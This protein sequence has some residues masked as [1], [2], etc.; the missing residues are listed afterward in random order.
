MSE[1]VF[2]FGVT[3]LAISA[4]TAAATMFAPIAGTSPPASRVCAG[5]LDSG[6]FRPAWCAK[7]PP[8]KS[9][10]R[11]RKALAAYQVNATWLAEAIATAIGNYQPISA[12]CKDNP[13]VDS[14]FVDTIIIGGMRLNGGEA[15][16]QAE[17]A[18]TDMT[19]VVDAVFTDSPTV[20]AEVKATL[21][22]LR[23]NLDGFGRIMDDLELAGD[24]YKMSA[25]NA[26]DDAMES[27]A[28][29]LV[30]T[31]QFSN[32]TMVSL[33]TMLGGTQERCKTTK[34][35]DPFT[36]K[37]MR[38]TAGATKTK[39][40]SAGDISMQYPTSLDVGGKAVWLPINLDSEAPS[41]Y[42]QVELTQDSK[43][44]A[45]VGGG[46]PADES[47][48]RI[49]VLGKPKRGKAMLRLTFQAAGGVEAI[50]TVTLRLR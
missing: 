22:G 3:T 9:H 18:V 7:K 37:A 6:E 20:P 25:C 8:P 43:R 27:A 28:E 15:K 4:V 46:T 44:L 12:Q 38:K 14:T 49:K 36:N 2:M 32:R 30:T 17:K 40:T 29:D 33:S 45:A 21:I 47:G 23:A 31:G 11:F 35:T 24:L 10:E 34:V 41:G 19:A 16:R 5:R 26:G 1:V 48:L 50:K 42:V 13:P 39:N